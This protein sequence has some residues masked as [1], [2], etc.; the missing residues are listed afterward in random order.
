MDANQQAPY[1]PNYYFRD[2]DEILTWTGH[3]KNTRF[4]SLF[5]MPKHQDGVNDFA[6]KTMCAFMRGC[7][8]PSLRLILGHI[9][10][11]RFHHH[12]DMP[13]HGHRE[14]R[15]DFYM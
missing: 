9:G 4:L 6:A 13:R 7:V 11:S 2:T 10:D 5:A 1:A 12:R 8:L 3:K 15:I 14:N